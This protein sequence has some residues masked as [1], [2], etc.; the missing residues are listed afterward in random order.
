M[1]RTLKLGI[2]LL[3]L[4]GIMSFGNLAKAA[5]ATPVQISPA[6]GATLSGTSVTL[7]W[8]VVSGAG[9]YSVGL[10]DL[11]T[12]VLASIP[13]VTGTS[14]TWSVT[15]GHSYRWDVASCTSFSSGDNTSNCPNRS[16]DRT[17]SVQ[18]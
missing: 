4:L 8:S 7:S 6:D 2:L 9:A 15:A 18:N 16:G 14:V 5:P 10:R 1:A 17:F 13:L 11:N 12:N 3:L